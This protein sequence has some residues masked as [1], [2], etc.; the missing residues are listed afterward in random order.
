MFSKFVS[1]EEKKAKPWVIPFPSLPNSLQ[2]FNFMKEWIN[3]Q[4]CCVIKKK[5]FFHFPLIRQRSC[6]AFPYLKNRCNHRNCYSERDLQA[7]ATKFNFTLKILVSRST[8]DL[9]NQNLRGGGERL[10]NP[11][12]L[13]PSGWWDDVYVQLVWK[14]MQWSS[15]AFQFVQGSAT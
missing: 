2:D 14:P 1:R 7:L 3:K 13:K 8:Q 6:S 10:E 11:N 4:T 12:T 15:F 9:L 5:R